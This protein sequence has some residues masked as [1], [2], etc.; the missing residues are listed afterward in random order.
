MQFQPPCFIYLFFFKVIQNLLLGSVVLVRLTVIVVVIIHH[1]NQEKV[2]NNITSFVY[3]C[4][5]LTSS[6]RLRSLLNQLLKHVCYFILS[7]FLV[8]AVRWNHSQQCQIQLSGNVLTNFLH[9]CWMMSM[10]E[11]QGR[12]NQAHACVMRLSCT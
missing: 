1:P 7:I 12:K 11:F 3:L 10:V 9:S 2:E 6:V 4:V 5:T 8:R